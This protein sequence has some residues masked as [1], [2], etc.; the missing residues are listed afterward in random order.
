[1]ILILTILALIIAAT[2]LIFTHIQSK[3]LIQQAKDHQKQ[4]RSGLK[5][6]AA[7]NEERREIAERLSA[8]IE[9]P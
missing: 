2:A 5:E 1:M 7:I 8:M 9:K 4:I 6:I 3:K